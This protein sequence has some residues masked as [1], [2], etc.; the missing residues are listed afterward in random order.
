MLLHILHHGSASVR[1]QY[2]EA[3]SEFLQLFAH[4]FALGLATHHKTTATA[5]R[6]KVREAEKIE[7]LRPT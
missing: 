5:S 4:P 1:S 6:N 3:H 2:I 7:S